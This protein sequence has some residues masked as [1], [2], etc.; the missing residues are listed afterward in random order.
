MPSYS[1][2]SHGARRGAAEAAYVLQ[3]AGW[4]PV[5][6]TRPIQS[7]KA[8]GL[9]ILVQPQEDDADAEDLT[10][11]VSDEDAT[12]MLAWVAR[13]HPPRAEQEGERHSSR[14]RRDADRGRHPG[15][16]RNSSR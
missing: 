13:Q 15:K 6:V 8:R 3:Q 16:T 14:P 10:G 4:T 2:Y 5:A 7:T 12:A 9:L 11:G 1:I